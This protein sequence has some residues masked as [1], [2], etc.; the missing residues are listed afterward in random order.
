M[1][2]I[3]AD[4]LKSAVDSRVYHN[5]NGIIKIIDE[6]PTINTVSSAHAHW[7]REFLTQTGCYEWY[8]RHDR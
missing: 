6:Q 7:I 5:H 3:D 2:L 8:G 1:R 4:S